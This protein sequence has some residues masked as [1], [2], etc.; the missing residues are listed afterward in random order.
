MPLSTATRPRAW[1]LALVVAML[2]ALLAT[3]SMPAP[4]I[5][6]AIPAPDVTARGVY[7]YDAATGIELFA[8]NEHE[9]VPIG[10]TVKIMPGFN[11]TL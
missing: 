6:A 7:A 11:S 2:A 4:D 3:L 5:A 8:K 9:R 1:R 10:S